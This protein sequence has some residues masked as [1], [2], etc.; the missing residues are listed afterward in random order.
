MILSLTQQQNVKKMC[1]YILL[2][3]VFFLF[4]NFKHSVYGTY[5]IHDLVLNSKY[6]NDFQESFHD[7]STF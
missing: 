1:A 5:S 4:L 3:I 7:K 2:P 6:V